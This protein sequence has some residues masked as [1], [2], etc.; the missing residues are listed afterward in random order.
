MS[1]KILITGIAGFLGH[2]LLEHILKNTDFEVIGLEGISYA[3]NLGRVK[4]I[5][6][7]TDNED[8]V[9]FIWH[10]LRSPF[11]ETVNHQI[12]Q[13]DYIVHLAAETHVDR[14]L[15]D[16]RPF[17]LTNVLGT[18]HLLEYVKH[19]Q[20]NL[21]KYIQFSTD[22]IF[23]AAPFG[24]D[25]KEWDTHKPSNPYAA[26]KAGA[27]DLAFSF[28][29]SFKLPICITHTMNMFGERQ[30]PEKFIPMTI[31]KVL[32]G[33]TVTIHGTENNVSTRKWIHCRNAAD[34]I[35]FLLDKAAPEDKYNIVGE[36]MGVLSV[37]K[38]IAEVLGKPLHFEYLDFHSTR[39]G[40]DL[41]YSLDGSKL[42]DMGWQAPVSFLGS[43][44][45]MVKWTL[46]NKEWINL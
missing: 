45:N 1:K 11:N 24:V 17:I 3:G 18:C 20:P 44:E 9:R 43:L 16:S 14:S 6:I 33:E 31:R 34:A 22:E 46:K 36:E 12:G 15:V 42:R 27:D 40:H 23:G 8:R 2:H 30:H 19:N 5:E 35:L 37:A 7:F 32:L 10:D 26:A 28:A 39:P 13:V 29:H 21:V 38:F 25:F 4:D 41:R